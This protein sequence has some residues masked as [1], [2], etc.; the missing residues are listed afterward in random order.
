ME[1]KKLLSNKSSWWARVRSL[2]EW[3]QKES[4][5]NEIE[6]YRIAIIEEKTINRVIWEGMEW[7]WSNIRNDRIEINR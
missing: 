5:E 7:R 6:A 2:G 4:W 1:K 3:K